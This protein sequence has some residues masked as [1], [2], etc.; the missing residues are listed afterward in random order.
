MVFEYIMQD[1]IFVSSI[2]K[3]NFINIKEC[4]KSQNS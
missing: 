1:S 4:Q 2:E 3:M